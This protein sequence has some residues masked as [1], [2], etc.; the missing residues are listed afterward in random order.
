MANSNGKTAQVLALVTEH[1][2]EQF[3]F[4]AKK[5]GFDPGTQLGNL[6]T[7]GKIRREGTKLKYRYW[8]KPKGAD[9]FWPEPPQK[10]K[11]RK[12]QKTRG[13]T[14]GD[15]VEIP[16]EAIGGYPHTPS[17]VPDDDATMLGTIILGVFNAMKRR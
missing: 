4:Y 17:G 6:R 11:P 2:G 13:P 8:P 5:L 7:Q 3:A 16:L 12:K 1:P 14:H 9:G 15:V 10:K